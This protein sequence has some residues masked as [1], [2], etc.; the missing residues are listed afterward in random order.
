MRRRTFLA[1]ST[2]L[3]VA[4]CVGS[5]S[6]GTPKTSDPEATTDSTS[7]AISTPADR[8]Y[9]ECSFQILHYREFP[10][11]VQNEIDGALADGKY[12]AEKVLLQETMNTADGCVVKD[13]VYYAPSV[14]QAGDKQVLRVNRDG[15]PELRD[16]RT[17]WVNNETQK[18]LVV[19]IRNEE[20]QQIR[21]PTHLPA[22]D[23]GPIHTTKKIGQYEVELE[24]G[25]ATETF[26]WNVN[27]SYG[28]PKLTVEKDGYDVK[29]SVADRPLCQFEYET[30]EA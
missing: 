26:D 3:L 12:T 13:D 15:D 30:T 7:T 20:G 18:E 5:R 28:S 11:P 19:R 29:Q 23:G 24:Y 17:L 10:E 4:G 9:R 25:E 16:S 21:E 1:L 2:T 14:E 8:T 27:W 22:D 6:V